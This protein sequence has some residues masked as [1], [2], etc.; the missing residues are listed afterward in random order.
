MERNNARRFA[1]NCDVDGLK[2]RFHRWEHDRF[3]QL[4]HRLWD[5]IQAATGMDTATLKRCFKVQVVRHETSTAGSLRTISLFGTAARCYQLLP[6]EL[7]DHL[8]EMHVKVYAIEAGEGAYEWLV[9]A[10]YAGIP[11]SNV[12]LSFFGNAGTKKSSKKSSGK[13]ARLG[14]RKS[15]K[16]S[17]IYKR[18]GERPGVEARVSDKT[19]KRCLREVLD[20]AMGID[21]PLPASALW[22]LLRA[23]VGV[24]GYAYMLD[25]LRGMGVTITD[26]I[27]GVSPDHDGDSPHIE[28]LDKQ[29]EESYRVTA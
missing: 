27:T 5:D 16:H 20:Y 10:V 8:A 9:D 1:A 14:S 24:V 15:D 7:A 4:Y 29:E 2:L 28:W 13:G 18:R 26:Y 22:R 17:V 23:K 25:T 12:Q 3:Q 11:F 6:W 19:L 21:E